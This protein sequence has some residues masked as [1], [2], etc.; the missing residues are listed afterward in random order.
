MDEEEVV[1]E[2]GKEESREKKRKVNVRDA[3]MHIYP[4]P[5][6]LLLSFLPFSQGGKSSKTQKNDI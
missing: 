4:H 2:E 5:L 3:Y 6:S 1:V